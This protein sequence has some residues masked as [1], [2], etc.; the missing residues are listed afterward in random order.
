M[1]VLC[2]DDSKKPANIPQEQ[3]IIKNNIYTVI[4]VVNLPLQPGVAGFLLKE[5]S[6][7]ADCFPYEFYSSNRF[8][9][10]TK[11]EVIEEQE[12][13]EEELSI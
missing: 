6:L 12:I 2:I 11:D 5:I 4:G 10:I 3:W 9:I 1:K 8:A 7:S 13:L